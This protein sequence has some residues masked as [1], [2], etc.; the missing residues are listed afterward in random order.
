VGAMLKV[1]ARALH[2]PEV[3]PT[4]TEDEAKK[5]VQKSVKQAVRD[6]RD[7]QI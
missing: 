2:L 3:L 4:A 1:R 7:L 6:G 5:L